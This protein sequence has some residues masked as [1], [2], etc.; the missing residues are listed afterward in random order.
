MKNFSNRLFR[1]TYLLLLAIASLVVVGCSTV[2]DYTLGSNM[3]PE[4][5][6]MVMRHLKFQGN[7]KIYFNSDKG[8]NDTLIIDG[9]NLLETRLYRTDS[10]LASNTGYGSIG[11]RRSDVLGLRKAS[12]ASTMLYMNAID[13]TDGFGYMPIFDTM[14]MLLTVKDYG[15]DT[16]TPIRYKVYRLHNSLAGNVLKY[17]EKRKE[18][19]VAYINCD[20]SGVYNPEEPIFEFTFPNNNLKQSLSTVM[21]PMTPT[22]YAWNGLVRELMLVPENYM[23]AEWDGYG[24][25]GVEIYKDDD[26]WSNKFFGLYI[27]PD[28]SS[29]VNSGKEGAIYTLDLASSGIM[30]QGR[31]RNPKDPS[32]IQDTV[33]MFYYFYDEAS[34]YNASVNSVKRDYTNAEIKEEDMDH[35]KPRAER[36][37]FSNCCVDGLGGPATE[38][39]FTD[40][41]LEELVALETTEQN[42]YSRMGINQCL[43]TIYLKGADYK[44][45]KTQNNASL[46]TPLINNSFVRL[47]SYTNYNTLSPITDYNYIYESTYDMEIAYNGYLDRSR[48]CYILNITAHIQRLFNSMRQGDG[49]YDISKADEALRTIYVGAE[50]TN[51]YAVSESF[52][53]GMPEDQEGNTVN[54]PIQIDLTYTLI[55]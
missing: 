33:G 47:G 46:L 49:T 36:R 45:D 14:F 51:P 27:E 53:Q 28:V 15:G 18:D 7:N 29:V 20:L 35:T 42:V 38:V 41:F 13:E 16:I 23:T 4:E 12:F 31:S 22:K 54:A 50:A 6:M 19:S 37:T 52:L 5:Q 2:E 21:V 55:K 32:M 10:L 48:A 3:M 9:K 44:W 34:T 11:V 26:T 40:D 1:Y 30:L 8:T 39:Y 17:D 24:N 25:K 43:L